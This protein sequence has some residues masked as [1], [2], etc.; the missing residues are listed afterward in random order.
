MRVA[1]GGQ[2]RASVVGY[3]EIVSPC[4]CVAVCGAVCVAVW[5]AACVGVSVGLCVGV[6]VAVC[7][8][9]CAG[10]CVAV[11]VAVCEQCCQVP[12]HT[13]TCVSTCF[14]LPNMHQASLV[15]KDVHL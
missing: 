7:A 6:C 10:E 3:S 11:C 4:M 13:C 5:V 12:F 1:V 8:G 2:W 9:E 14:T 15:D